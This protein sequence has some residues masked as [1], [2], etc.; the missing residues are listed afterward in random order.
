MRSGAGG[1]RR[2]GPDPATFT[3]APVIPSTLPYVTCAPPSVTGA[4]IATAVCTFDLSSTQLLPVTT[5]TNPFDLREPL[6]NDVAD[7]SALDATASVLT[8][9]RY[10]G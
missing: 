10:T 8:T 4:T 5:M 1:T 2:E 7:A 9:P 6:A 3:P